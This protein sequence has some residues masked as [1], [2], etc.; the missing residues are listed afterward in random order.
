[1][2]LLKF[3]FKREAIWMM[4]LTLVPALVGLLLVFSVWLAR[5]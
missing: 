3:T 4:L 1:L 5:H 2:K